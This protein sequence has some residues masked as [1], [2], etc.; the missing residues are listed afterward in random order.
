MLFPS[1]GLSRHEN[2]GGERVRVKGKA[3]GGWRSGP[4]RPDLLWSQG[5]SVIIEGSLMKWFLAHM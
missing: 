4:A 2:T 3:E 5:M 1:R